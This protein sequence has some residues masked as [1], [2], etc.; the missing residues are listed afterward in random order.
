MSP[1][2]VL[3]GKFEIVGTT[4]EADGRQPAVKSEAVVF[5]V[6]DRRAPGNTLY[7][8]RDRS[9]DEAWD[10]SIRRLAIASA[11]RLH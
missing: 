5:D 7:V 4:G 8:C 9:F 6:I 2:R 11:S 10:L 3:V 1:F